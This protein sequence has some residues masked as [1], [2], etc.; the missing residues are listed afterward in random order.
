MVELKAYLIQTDAFHFNTAGYAA[1]A[2][3]QPEG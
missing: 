1:P 2:S 3:F